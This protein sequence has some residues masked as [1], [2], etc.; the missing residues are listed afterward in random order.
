MASYVALAISL[1]MHNVNA[2]CVFVTNASLETASKSDL[3]PIRLIGKWGPF[4]IR[5]ANNGYTYSYYKN[6]YI[7]IVRDRHLQIGKE[8][9][10]YYRYNIKVA[11]NYL[12]SRFLSDFLK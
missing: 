1:H 10:R 5:I 9:L 11:N 2:A 12:V 7:L 4:I 3:N 8:Q 6:N